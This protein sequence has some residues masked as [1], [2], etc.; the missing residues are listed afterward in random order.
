MGGIAI[1]SACHLAA[2][3]EADRIGSVRQTV[4]L[5]TPHLGAPLEQFV[6]RVTAAPRAA[7]Y[8]EVPLLPDAAH[9][10]VSAGA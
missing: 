3:E 5:G 8:S 6:H 7:A 2:L 10:F 9:Y 4:S 1:R